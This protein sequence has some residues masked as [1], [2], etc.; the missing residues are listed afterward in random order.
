MTR[1]SNQT[2]IVNIILGALAL[3]LLFA[4]LVQQNNITSKGFEI[5]S[6]SSTLKGINSRYND[7]IIQ[8]ASLDRMAE[9]EAFAIEK[10]MVEVSQIIYVYESGKVALKKI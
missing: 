10:G 9:I 8:K 1:T 7:L 2:I 4:Y 6:L 3:S 5:N